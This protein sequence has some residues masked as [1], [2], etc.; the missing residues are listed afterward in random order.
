MEPAIY[1][2]ILTGYGAE[3]FAVNEH[4]TLYFNSNRVADALSE[5][6][7]SQSFSADSEQFSSTSEDRR[8]FVLNVL[9]R[10]VGTTPTR[11]SEPI[12]LRVRATDE[13]YERAAATKFKFPHKLYLANVSLSADTVDA[14][15]EYPVIR[16]SA[17]GGALAYRLAAAHR[18]ADGVNAISAFRYDVPTNELRVNSAIVPGRYEVLNYNT[19]NFFL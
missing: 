10:E 17:E 3:K 15:V 18:S 14:G 2:Y 11:S 1:Q 8:H 9:A 5:L 6:S 13:D 16:V 4:G 12:R 7:T 19:R